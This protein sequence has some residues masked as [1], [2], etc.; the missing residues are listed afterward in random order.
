MNFRSTDYLTLLA[1][2]R[3]HILLERSLSRGHLKGDLISIKLPSGKDIEVRAQG[4]FVVCPVVMPPEILND[5][6]R[7][8]LVGQDHAEDFQDRAV[9]RLTEDGRK[10][11]QDALAA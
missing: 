5:F 1:K 2:E 7:A 11:A 4:G 9:F 8:N 3:A 10:R 6:I